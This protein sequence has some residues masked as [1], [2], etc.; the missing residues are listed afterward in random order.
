MKAVRTLL[1]ILVPIAV[2]VAGVTM[3]A[4][5]IIRGGIESEGP[6]IT[7]TDL[8]VESVSVSIIGGSAGMRGLHIGNP[9]G[10]KAPYSIELR[11]IDITLDPMSLVGD[12]I[13][14]HKIEIV[15]PHIIY[16]VGKRGSNLEQISKNIERASGLAESEE[17]AAPSVK[18]V[19]EDFRLIDAEVTVIQSL[20]GKSEQTITIP[21]L[22]LTDI[23]RKGD[24][25]VAAEAAKQIMGA[26]MAEVQKQLTKGKVRGLLDSAGD[27]LG[28][29][30]DKFKGLFGGGK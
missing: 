11:S 5:S 10:F 23:G 4:G 16:E 12:E 24:G 25:V 6:T 22:H 28:S 7:G 30:G 9:E 19:I 27:G 29:V 17:E 18:L 20:V 2:I 21:E 1:Y 26:L 15:S 14:I 3:M 13:L 8:T